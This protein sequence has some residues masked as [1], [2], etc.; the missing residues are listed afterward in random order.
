MGLFEGLPEPK[1]ETA[2]QARYDF[3]REFGEQIAK[4]HG[5]VSLCVLVGGPGGD[6]SSARDTRI[7]ILERLSELG[8]NT[9]FSEHLKPGDGEHVS[10][11]TKRYLSANLADAIVLLVNGAPGESGEDLDF[12]DYIDV[13]SRCLLLAP[14]RY[15][16]DYSA[17]GPVRT[18]DERY[19]GVYWYSE[20]EMERDAVV[21]RAVARVEALRQIH[22]RLTKVRQ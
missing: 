11:W 19:G 12:V 8:H 13:S 14:L 3:E 9:V 16:D 1:T 6:G 22:Y 17:L 7:R 4:I 18:L 2:R 5:S 20:E 21:T 15:K 10:E